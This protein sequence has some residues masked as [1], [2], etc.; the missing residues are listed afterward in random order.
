MKNSKKLWVF[1]KKVIVTKKSCSSI[2]SKNK[3]TDEHLFSHFKKFLLKSLL[4]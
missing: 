4:N 1:K 3:K 2:R